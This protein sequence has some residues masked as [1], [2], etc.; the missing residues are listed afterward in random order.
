MVAIVALAKVFLQALGFSVSVA[1]PVLHIH[2]FII[3]W[4]YVIVALCLFSTKLPSLQSF[5]SFGLCCEVN[6]TVN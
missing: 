6:R 5:C 2:S 1:L 3:H 4:H